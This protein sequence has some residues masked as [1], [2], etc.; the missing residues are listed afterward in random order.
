MFWIIIAIFVIYLIT[1]TWE[2]LLALIVGY[3]LFMFIRGK[4]EDARKREEKLIRHKSPMLC[5]KC[6]VPGCGIAI[7]DKYGG[8]ICHRHILE[9]S[10][11]DNCKKAVL[12]DWN[13]TC[14]HRKT[15]SQRHFTMIR[16]RY[17]PQTED[18][19]STDDDD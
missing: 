4:N 7:I 11:C 6:A 19:S 14:E 3:V 16:Q 15:S 13:Q 8:V 12:S 17:I 18:S 5:Q 10:W 9:W 1:Q 2:I